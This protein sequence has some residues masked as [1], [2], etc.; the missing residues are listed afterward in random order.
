MQR[1]AIALL[2]S[3]VLLVSGCSKF[4]YER[5]QMI[6]PDVDTKEDVQQILGE[7]ERKGGDFWYYEDDD[8]EEFAAARIFFYFDTNVVRGKEWISAADGGT[9]EGQDPDADVEPEGLEIRRERT[10]VRTYDD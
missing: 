10:R 7:P 2:G 9:W 5:F 6:K 4:T 3:G 1:F 8:E